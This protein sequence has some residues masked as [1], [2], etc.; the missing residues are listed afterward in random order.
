MTRRCASHGPGFYL[1]LT[2]PIGRY[3]QI[4][5]GVSFTWLLRC[6]QCGSTFEIDLAPDQSLLLATRR[7]PCPDCFHLP[8]D[9]PQRSPWTVPKVHAIVSLKHYW[10]APS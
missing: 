10:P 4:V 3:N 8:A 1:I 7:T 2:R 6:Q 9:G 5:S